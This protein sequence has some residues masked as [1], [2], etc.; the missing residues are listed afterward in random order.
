M[1]AA[2]TR[3][4]ENR[5]PEE[6]VLLGLGLSS[7]TVLRIAGDDVFG[8]AV[9]SASKLREDTSGPWDILVTQEFVDHCEGLDAE[10]LDP[11]DFIPPGSKGAYKV[12][13]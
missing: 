9:N 1:Q 8:E 11:I 4:N 13:Y 12:I 7:G 5:P 3:Y 2:C 6:H 10:S